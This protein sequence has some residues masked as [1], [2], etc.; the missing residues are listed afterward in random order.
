MSDYVANKKPAVY[1]TFLVLVLQYFI[2]D[3]FVRGL[4]AQ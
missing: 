4:S 1:S 3:Y 2:V